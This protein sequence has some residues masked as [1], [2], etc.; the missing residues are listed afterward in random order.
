MF[1]AWGFPPKEVPYVPVRPV[2][3]TPDS[4]ASE[5]IATVSQPP[6]SSLTVSVPPN[7]HASET[8]HCSTSTQSSLRNVSTHSAASTSTSL[9][10]NYKWKSSSNKHSVQ[11]S[12]MLK[13][14]AKDQ[15]FMCSIVVEEC[16]P[17]KFN[18]DTD[19]NMDTNTYEYGGNSNF[20]D[21]SDFDTNNEDISLDNFNDDNE[22]IAP[23]HINNENILPP[24]VPEIPREKTV[25][26]RKICSTPLQLP[27]TLWTTVCHPQGEYFLICH[28]SYQDGFAV[29]RGIRFTSAMTPPD[30]H[31]GDKKVL[32][33]ECENV[34]SVEDV[35]RLVS[36]VDELSLCPG[37]GS[38][39]GHS[40]VCAEIARTSETKEII[41]CAACNMLRL[42][43]RRRSVDLTQS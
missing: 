43:N 6:S 21:L 19:D 11:Y 7:S 20:E 34:N 41:P 13:N 15:N 36:V 9:K 37:T 2:R 18:N 35:E 29:D 39:L 32:L 14:V 33:L 17:S 10:L 25:L 8:A 27:S 3:Q 5:D 23:Q 28:V 31:I 42:V 38:E 40:K 24:K 4:T 16:E 26:F 1:Q 12:K 22:N 30:V